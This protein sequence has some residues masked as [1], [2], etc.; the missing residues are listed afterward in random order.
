M[1]RRQQ[2]TAVSSSAYRVSEK[3]PQ[4][5]ISIFNLFVFAVVLKKQIPR[6]Q[7][8][9]FAGKYKATD[10]AEAECVRERGD[11]YKPHGLGDARDGLSEFGG[12]AKFLPESTQSVDAITERKV[13]K[14]HFLT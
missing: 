6:L 7:S 2:K 14:S 12:G 8:C 9:E 3:K 10:G 4:S 13:N 1:L 5:R 11:S